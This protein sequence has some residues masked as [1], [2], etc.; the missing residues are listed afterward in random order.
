MNEF[1]TLFD[2]IYWSFTK[3]RSWRNCWC[4]FKDVFLWEDGVQLNRILAKWSIT[5]SSVQG[6]FHF[7]ENHLVDSEMDHQFYVLIFLCVCYGQL[8]GLFKRVFL[9]EDEVQLDRILAKWS[10]TWSSIQGFVIFDDS[11]LVDPEMDHQFDGVVFSCVCYEQSHGLFKRVFLWEDEVQLD[12]ILAK[13]SITWSSVQGSFHFNENHLVG[14]E[15]NHQ[16]SVVCNRRETLFTQRLF[17]FDFL[18]TFHLLNP[19]LFNVIKIG[20][21]QWLISFFQNWNRV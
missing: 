16:C 19:R 6:S 18:R 2:D 10:I 3:D 14:P 13:W 9:W 8:H 15:M 4:L 5:W 7:D 12:W 20:N 21:Y 1:E 17:W 11:Q